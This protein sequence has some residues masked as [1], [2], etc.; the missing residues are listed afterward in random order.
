MVNFPPGS[1]CIQVAYHLSDDFGEHY[2]SVRLLGDDT[3]KPA[4]LESAQSVIQ[5]YKQEDE[6]KLLTEF[7]KL[8]ISDDDKKSK[9]QQKQQKQSKYQKQP[10]RQKP[11]RKKNGNKRYTIE[12]GDKKCLCGSKKKAKFCCQKKTQFMESKLN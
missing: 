5:K 8:S 1:K 10:K 2:T 11:E 7:S 9:K 4:R 6:A 3:E 12:G